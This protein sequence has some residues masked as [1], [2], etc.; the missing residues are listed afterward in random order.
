MWVMRR[1][2]IGHKRPPALP[3]VAAWSVLLRLEVFRPKGYKQLRS[4]NGRTREN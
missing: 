3:S 4:E 1:L 2:R